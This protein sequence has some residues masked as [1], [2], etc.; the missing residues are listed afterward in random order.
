MNWHKIQEIKHTHYK[1]N[2]G[3]CELAQ[4]SR[5]SSTPI[6]NSIK[7]GVN[8]HKIH[9]I[10]HT[11]AYITP[12]SRVII[13]VLFISTLLIEAFLADI[14]VEMIQSSVNRLVII[15]HLYRRKCFGTIFT[16]DTVPDQSI[17]PCGVLDFLNFVPIHASLDRVSHSNTMEVFT[18]TR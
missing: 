3:G 15:P 11:P 9:E 16:I 18:P 8:W 10:E 13:T 1:L 17:P 14:A 6:R 2:Q 4:N 7:V 5:K 12:Q